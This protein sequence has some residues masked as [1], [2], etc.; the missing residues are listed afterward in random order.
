MAKFLQKKLFTF[1][2]KKIQ[3]YEG[4]KR[5]KNKN[6]LHDL[7]LLKNTTNIKKNTFYILLASW[8]Y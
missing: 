2:N 1:L 5:K 6:T 8:I 4:K 3:E 7:T